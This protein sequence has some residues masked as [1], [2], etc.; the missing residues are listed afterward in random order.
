MEPRKPSNQEASKGPKATTLAFIALMGLLGAASCGS[1][2]SANVC[3]PG[4]SLACGSSGLCFQRCNS[5]GTGYGACDYCEGNGGS[6]LASHSEEQVDFV[7]GRAHQRLEERYRQ[8]AEETAAY[9][10][11]LPFLA[12]EIDRIA[13]EASR[14]CVVVR[15]GRALTGSA[16]RDASRR[17]LT[18]RD[19]C[20]FGRASRL[21]LGHELGHGAPR[22][23]VIAQAQKLVSCRNYWRRRRDSNPRNPYEFAGFQNR[24]LEP[25][26]HSS[27]D[28]FSYHGAGSTAGSRGA[29]GHP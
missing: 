20:G 5:D 24:C 26:G 17:P 29:S 23:T 3:S 7:T 15:T 12:G 19:R 8:A 4:S 18:V 11:E 10:A 27:G 6:A 9:E 22:R 2:E 28:R 21:Q 13:F 1:S 16:E 14:G 25:L